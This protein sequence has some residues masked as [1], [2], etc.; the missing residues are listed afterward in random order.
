M[1]LSITASLGYCIAD[2]SNDKA[3]SQP[4]SKMGLYR[5]TRTRLDLT[6]DMLDQIL[7][8][9]SCC[10]SM[11]HCLQGYSQLKV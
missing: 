4:R 6:F 7:K 1:C 3:S 2:L 10:R 8:A 9:R 11:Y 5:K